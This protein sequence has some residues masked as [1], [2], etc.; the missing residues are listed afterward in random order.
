M[1]NKK[2]TSYTIDEDVIIRLNV[3]AAKLNINKS[4]LVERLLREGLDKISS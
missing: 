3:E 1:A 2:R 4:D